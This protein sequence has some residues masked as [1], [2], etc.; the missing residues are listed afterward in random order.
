MRLPLRAPYALALL[1]TACGGGGGNP[2][3]SSGGIV[4][5]PPK[6]PATQ[7]G[8]L[9]GG[10][11]LVPVAVNGGTVD[12][13]QPAV[14]TQLLEGLQ[15][16]S[17]AITGTP[18]CAV[19]TY[20]V[21]YHTVGGAAE[22]T[23]ASTAIMVPSGADGACQGGRPVLL[24]AHGTSALK[25]T[26]MSNLGAAEA[27]LV[28]AM[29]AAQGYIVVAPNYTGYAGSSLTYHPYLDAV[30]QSN[31]MV[32]ALRAARLVFAKIGAA[33]GGKLVLT[34]YSQGGHVALATQRAMQTTYGTE[35][36]VTAAAPL[37]GPYA[38]IRFGDAIF[39]GAP[40]LGSSGFLPM[41]INAAQHANAGLYAKP[42][43]V[44]EDKYAGAIADLL[45]GAQSLGEL[46]AAGRL[47]NDV[48]FGQDALPQA[49]GY[50]ARFGA[51]HLLKTSY[52]DSYLAD[53]RGSP[54]D[55]SGA[56]PLNC[57][58]GHLL[59]KW[60]VRNDLR[61]YVP[62]V[63]LLLCGGDQD[64]V[65]PYGNTE[66]AAAYFSAQGKPASSL[67][68]LN[69]DGG[70][71]LDGYTSARTAFQGAKAA[72]RLSV[73]A[74]GGNAAAADQAVNDAYHAGLVAPFC[75]RASRDFFHTL[76][77]R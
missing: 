74:A 25:S 76:L 46:V 51:D 14:F 72:L 75:M 13:L 58:P 52:H 41:L 48:L 31:D 33:D 28:A 56:N 73:L 40:T 55:I 24:Y 70:L 3:T 1:L 47:P 44:Y 42:G 32:D 17:S 54:C 69:L 11:T 26:D 36:N 12:T 63:P 62:A 59:R 68:A 10:A 43:D 39:G 29:Y 16:G 20:T 37:S 5:D 71:G 67:T 23:D 35:F 34:G 61:S 7:R 50:G 64:P 2:G 49:A 21:K 18:S 77:A 66:A 30:A 6:P 65:V 15:K 19:T 4:V 57:A 53:M 8:T 45:P 22:D 27:R 60:L 9:I 38:L